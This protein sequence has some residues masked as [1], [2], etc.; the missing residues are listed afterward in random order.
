[1]TP[2]FFQ[3]TLKV[4]LH[5]GKEF[6][7]LRDRQSGEGDLP[8]G[9]LSPG[10]IYHPWQESIA[11]ELREELGEDLRYKLDDG[12][13]FVEP[14]WIKNGGHEALA[15][16]F[17]ADYEGGQIVLS[18]EHDRMAWADPETFQPAEWFSDH[19]LR[20]VEKYLK[21]TRRRLTLG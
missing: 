17:R 8:G 19:L 11:R 4:L 15:V 16:F 5:R 10:E 7:V 6:L 3:I 2:G 14:H 13:L 12:P 20:S 9:R 21:D 1:M 18:D